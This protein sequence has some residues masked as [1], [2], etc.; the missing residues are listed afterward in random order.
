[1]R[2]EG[3]VVA[4]EGRIARVRMKPGPECGSCCACSALGGSGR[5]LEIDT[6]LPVA[7]GSRVLVEVPRGNP[8]LSVALLFVLPLAGLIAA[9]VVGTEAGLGDGASVALGFGTLGALFALAAAVDKAVAR[10]RLQPP[11]IVELLGGEHP[12]SG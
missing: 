4:V 8:W 12:G 11:A 5:E 3:T 6:Q 2:E 7:V 9:L 10:K 1:M